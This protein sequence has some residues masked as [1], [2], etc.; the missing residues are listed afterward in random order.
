MAE[1]VNLTDPNLHEPKGAAAASEDEVFVADG[2][3]SG[4][5]QKIQDTSL[6]GISANGNAG[7]QLVSDGAGGFEFII[8]TDAYYGEAYISENATPTVIGTGNTFQKVGTTLTWTEGHADNVV[9]ATDHWVIQAD[10]DYKVT[11]IVNATAG[12]TNKHYTIAF[13]DDSG[14]G[15]TALTHSQGKF[16]TTGTSDLRQVVI[17]AIDTYAAGDLVYLLLKNVDD[18]TGITLT[19]VTFLIE[20]KELT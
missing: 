2:N 19:D 7:E 9:W 1:H 16:R 15:I 14:G 17:S 20:V 13:G 3:G 4:A 18:T 8:P 11:A 5:F 6:E 10:G 12:G